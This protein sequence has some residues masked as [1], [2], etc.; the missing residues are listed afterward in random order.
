MEAIS[1][2][3]YAKLVGYTGENPTLKKIQ[4]FAQDELDWTIWD[5]PTEEYSYALE[6][7]DNCSEELVYVQTEIGVRVC[8]K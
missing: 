2:Q 6:A 3:D 5:Y 1:I 8:E 4:E 7:H